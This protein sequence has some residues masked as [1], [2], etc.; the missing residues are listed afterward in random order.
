MQ[1]FVKTP[2]R[3]TITLE[4]EPSDTIETI[5]FKILDKEGIPIELQKLIFTLKAIK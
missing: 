3:K 5:T 1:I 4:V 2:T